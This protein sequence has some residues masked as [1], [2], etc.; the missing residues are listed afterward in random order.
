[1]KNSFWQ[2]D[3]W[4]RHF[5]AHL[6]SIAVGG[7]FDK[8][9]QT[10]FNYWFNRSSEEIENDSSDDIEDTPFLLQDLSDKSLKKLEI[11]LSKVLTGPQT[12]KAI[13]ILRGLGESASPKDEEDTKVSFDVIFSPYLI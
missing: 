2:L 7:D 1:M 10:I 5:Q 4:F 3:Q 8:I 12:E 11:S 13:S 9:N 6:L